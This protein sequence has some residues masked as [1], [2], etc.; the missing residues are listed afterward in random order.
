M[1]PEIRELN[2]S[3]LPALISNLEK[4]LETHLFVA[5]RAEEVLAKKSSSSILGYFEDGELKGGVLFSQSCT[6]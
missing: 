3:D 1:Y 4:D 5:S 2:L 6:I